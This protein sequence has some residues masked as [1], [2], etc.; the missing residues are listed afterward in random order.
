MDH[1]I[2]EEVCYA[3]HVSGGAMAGV[4]LGTTFLLRCAAQA[5]ALQV[6]DA[7]DK[8]CCQTTGLALSLQRQA[9]E[10][11][12]LPSDTRSN[13]KSYAAPQRCSDESLTAWHGCRPWLAALALSEL[14]HTG[15]KRP[16]RWKTAAAAAAQHKSARKK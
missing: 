9:L 15:D 13:F 4:P 2:Q 3:L 1:S 12:S 10:C 16:Q 5:L 14:Q 7:Q 8:L 6:A 11:A